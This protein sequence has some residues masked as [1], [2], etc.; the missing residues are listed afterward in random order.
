M[1]FEYYLFSNKS[2]NVWVAENSL[3]TAYKPIVFPKDDKIDVNNKILMVLRKTASDRI[4]TIHYLK[5]GQYM[6]YSE[7]VNKDTKNHFFPK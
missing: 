2:K 1:Y 3:L 6:Y 5:N 4:G 7:V